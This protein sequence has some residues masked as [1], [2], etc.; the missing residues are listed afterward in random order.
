MHKSRHFFL[1]VHKKW[2]HRNFTDQ[3]YIFVKKRNFIRKLVGYTLGMRAFLVSFQTLCCCI[4]TDTLKPSNWI[5]LARLHLSIESCYLT[6]SY[7]LK[8][9]RYTVHRSHISKDFASVMMVD[10]RR[11]KLIC[12]SNRLLAKDS[13]SCSKNRSGSIR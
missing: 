8:S 1:A 3:K 7:I 11:S 4:S 10:T 6:A 13:K 12:S 2:L 5:H 9:R